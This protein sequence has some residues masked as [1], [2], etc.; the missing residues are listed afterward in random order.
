M[1]TDSDKTPA[2]HTA[3]ETSATPE[4]ESS[5]TSA[6]ATRTAEKAPGSDIEDKLAKAEQEIIKLKDHYARALADLD[7]YRRRVV[8]EK[9]DLRKFATQGLLEDMLPILDNLG[10]GLA[11]AENLP[12]AKPV[13]DGFKMIANQI[14][15][16]LEQHGLREINPVG[17]LFDPNLHESLSQAPH[18]TIPDHHV[19]EVFRIGYKL[20]DRLIRPA[21]VT[22]STGPAAESS[23]TPA[24]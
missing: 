23:E 17:E 20:H 3:P 24:N 7:N 12:E 10:I 13:T 1:T 19:A 9:E 6:E 4:P 22:L 5:A 16:T 18:P 21:S 8:R 11:T 2:D 15:T 14:K